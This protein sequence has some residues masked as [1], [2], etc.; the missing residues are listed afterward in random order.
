MSSLRSQDMSLYQIMINRDN[1]WEIMSK[2]LEVD[3]VHY[4]SLTD[5]KQP[6]ELLYV[7][8]VRRSEEIARKIAYIEK[9]YA[10]YAVPIKGPEN[11]DQLDQAI[12]SI[13]NE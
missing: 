8:S 10:D 2:F 6:H 4:V 13:C 5:H 1:A 11:L 7:D 9:M 3:Y 12:E